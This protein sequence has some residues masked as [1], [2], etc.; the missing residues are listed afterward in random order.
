MSQEIKDKILELI[1]TH[2]EHE[3]R[4]CDTG[5]DMEWGC[6]SECNDMAVERVFDYLKTL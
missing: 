5:E 1:S 6:R 2:T 3:G 4:Y